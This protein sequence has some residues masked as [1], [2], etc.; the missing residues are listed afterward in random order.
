MPNAPRKIAA[1]TSPRLSRLTKTSA[2][3]PTVYPIAMN[4]TSFS[5]AL[6]IPLIPRRITSA[7]SADVRQP[8]N[9]GGTEKLTFI[10]CAIVLT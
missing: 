4:G 6:P 9:T 7:T 1:K 8:V 10:V 3:A 5:A 2:S